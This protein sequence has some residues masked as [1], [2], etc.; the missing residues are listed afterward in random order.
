MSGVGPRGSR[1]LP[2]RLIHHTLNP[3]LLAPRTSKEFEDTKRIARFGTR[4]TIALMIAGTAANAVII[5]LAPN[6]Y[7]ALLA[8][9]FSGGCWTAAAG[10]RISRSC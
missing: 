9:V 5:A 2:A 10:A 4:P 6:L 7:V 1:G 3:K 8:A